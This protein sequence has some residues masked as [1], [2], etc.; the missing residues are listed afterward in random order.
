MKTVKDFEI[1]GKKVLLRSDFNVPLDDSGAIVDD[2]RIQKSLETIQYLISQKAK[3]ILLAHLG[4]PEGEIVERLKVKVIKERLEQLLGVEIKYA[5]DCVGPAVESAV[6]HL[7]DGEVLLLEN[8]RFHKEETENSAEFSKELSHVADLYINDAFD[9]CHR[10]HASVVG[11]PQFLPHGAGLLLEKEVAVLSQIMQRPLRPMVAIIG[12]AKAE[13]KAKLAD[14]F[15]AFADLV[16]VS[17]LIKQALVE[18]KVPLQYPEKVFGPR[19]DL[20]APDITAA[21]IERIVQRILQAKTVF[22]NGPFGK[23]EDGEHE[24]GT[25]AIANAII[26]SGAFSVVGGGETIAFLGKEG[27]LDK[28]NHVSTGGGAMLS[29]LAAEELPGLKALE[30]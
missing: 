12:G 20:Q 15:C 23:F 25:L 6:L 19:E 7:Q 22:W 1:A 16:I 28:F 11:V 29:Y 14:P 2:F 27:I 18:K 24:K 9:V 17:G 8:V 10:A 21:D 30:L 4:E 26:E 13:T 5:D 3:V